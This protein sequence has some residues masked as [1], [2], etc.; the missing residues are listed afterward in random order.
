MDFGFFKRHPYITGA[1]VVVGGVVFF[2]FFTSNS[3]GGAVVP[4]SGADPN[5][6]ALQIAQMQSN[7]VSAGYAAQLEAKRIESATA[8]ELGSMSYDL[9]ALKVAASQVLG[10]G[11]IDSQNKMTAA[12][13]ESVRIQSANQLQAHALDLANASEARQQQ[14]QLNALEM[15]RQSEREAWQYTLNYQQQQQNYDL[16]N[17]LIDKLKAA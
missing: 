10:L 1:V 16:Q 14:I 7:N 13:L 15:A 17:K 2:M 11:A 12:Q 5:A 3:G 8:I 6:T 4:Q 9:E